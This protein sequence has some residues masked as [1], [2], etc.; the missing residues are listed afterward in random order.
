MALRKMVATRFSN[1]AK[2]ASPEA[3]PPPP[4]PATSLLR[5]LLPGSG[6]DEPGLLRQFLQRRPFFHAATTPP[7]RLA[8][9][10]GDG[11]MDRIREMNGSRIRLEGL[12]PPTTKRTDDA[13]VSVAEARKVARAARMEVARARLR[14]TGRACLSYSEFSQVCREVA[15]GME[16]GT[17]LGRALDESGAVIVFGDIVF[18]RPE[19]VTKAIESMIPPSLSSQSDPRSRELKAMEGKKTEIDVK[20]EALVKREMWCGLA[21]LALQTAGFMRLTF[22][23]L[24]W[25]V[26]EP[27]CFYVTSLYFMVGYAFFLRTSRDPSFEGFFE[28]RLAAKRKR[29]MKARNFD[30]NRFN[31]LKSDGGAFSLSRPAEECSASSWPCCDCHGR[32]STL[33]GAAHDGNIID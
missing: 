6:A 3:I 26:M 12:L 16:E 1:V 10:V 23:E 4:R 20:A 9:P 24:S 25:D 32:R 19:M 13:A 30:V 17:G 22:W 31:E 14:G 33:I 28:S 21:F 7:A 8:L 2:I 29:L 15:G 11:V 5:R 18:V 27:I